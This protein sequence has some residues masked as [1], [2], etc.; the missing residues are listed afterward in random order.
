M[1]G[2]AR[3]QSLIVP[4]GII[5]G[6]LVLIAPLPASVLDALLAANLAVS[7]VVLLTTLSVKTPLEFSVFP[8]LL[9]ATTLSR[10]V[11]NVASTRLILTEAGTARLDAAGKIIRA[12]GEFVTGDKPLVGLILFAIIAVIQF[13]VIT[14]GASRIGEVAARFALD[15]LPGRQ[16]A[17]DADLQSGQ[18]DDREAQRRR[19][20][21]TEQVDFYAAMDGASKFVRGDAVAAMLIIAINIV[22]GLG[23]GVF[24]AGLELREAAAIFTKLTI[25]DG[26][27]AQ[28]PALLISLGAALLVTRS[29]QQMDLPQELLRQLY[30]RPQVLVVAAGFLVL[31]MFVRLP[32]GPLATLACGC[33][34]LALVSTR[35]AR[36]QAAEPPPAPPPATPARPQAT[37]EKRIEDYLAVEPME[38]EIGVGLVRLADP[39]RG[40]D[41]L[42]QV[43]EVRRRVAAELGIVLPRVRIRDNLS[44]GKHQ[45][46]IKIAGN[47]VA[48]GG[49]YPERVLA[50]ERDAGALPLAGE[51]TTEPSSK[52]PA[53]WIDPEQAPTAKRQGYLI[54]EPTAAAANHLRH[55]VREHAPDLMT[56]DA[57]KHL[58]EELKKTSPAVV[59]ELLPGLL[60]LGQ[61][62]QVLQM[63]LRE[64][65]P[66]RPLSVILE[67]LGDHAAHTQDPVSLT[68]AVRQRLARTI[69]TR[70]R[71]SERRLHVV[72][73]DPALEE[74]VLAGLHRLDRGLSVRLPPQAVQRLCE[75]LGREVERLTRTGRPA[76]VLVSPEI[77]AGLK[78][79][80]AARLPELVVLSYHEITHDTLVET[81]RTVLEPVLAAA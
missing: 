43:T 53:V 75:L 32:V 81:V 58:L 40:G 28:I 37:S 18:I 66:L 29:S 33:L 62:Q 27:V 49:A 6:V 74:R 39:H 21:L 31:L 56:R 15:G 4:I 8:S 10:L 17:I 25:G 36:R 63:L 45:Y 60:K 46:R 22:G 80:T 12:F 70:Y 48:D 16:M 7:V 44:L 30:S 65:V 2:L 79:L 76:V 3:W 13:V 47:P 59:E 52:R 26:L 68:E 51:R 19:R 23:V 54:V 64:G 5:A 55:V 71:D 35:R 61:V 11:L 14:K 34:G 1:S 57:A 77:R 42:A 78:Q 41:L 72:T 24:D 9:L 73:L 50:I 69:C 67:A 38:M 20:E